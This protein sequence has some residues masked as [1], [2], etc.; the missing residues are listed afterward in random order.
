MFVR[1]HAGDLNTPILNQV[2]AIAG[3]AFFENLFSFRKR[4][5]AGN[6]LQRL[7]VGGGQSTKNITGF[8]CHVK[9]SV[10]KPLAH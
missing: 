5:F 2:E 6:G 10:T 3:V 4:A 1:E 8:H 7:K 9:A